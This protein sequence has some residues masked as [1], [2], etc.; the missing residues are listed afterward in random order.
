MEAD[1]KYHNNEDGSKSFQVPV[2]FMDKAQGKVNELSS[3][4]LEIL[5]VSVKE[6]SR[7]LDCESAFDTSVLCK[8]VEQAKVSDA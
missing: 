1:I 6:L 2:E 8:K 3:Y 7:S 5:L 4:D